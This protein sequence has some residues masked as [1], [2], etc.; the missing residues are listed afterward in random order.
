MQLLLSTFSMLY[1]SLNCI[2]TRHYP[3]ILYPSCFFHDSFLL[4]MHAVARETNLHA[5]FSLLICQTMLNLRL[6][7]TF[8]FIYSIYHV[9]CPCMQCMPYIY[10]TVSSIHN[11][12]SIGIHTISMHLYWLICNVHV[13]VFYDA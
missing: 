4:Y 3:H 9:I 2:I 5:P 6:I 13:Y 10:K 8:F 1:C 12:L 7:C 11:V